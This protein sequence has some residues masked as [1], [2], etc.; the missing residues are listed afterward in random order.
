MNNLSINQDLVQSLYKEDDL[1][2]EINNQ[3]DS[4]I[5]TS[6]KGQSIQMGNIND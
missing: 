3:I 6:K 1:S 2:N 5:S 4:C